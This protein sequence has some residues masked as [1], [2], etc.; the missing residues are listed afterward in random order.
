MP[1]YCA[2]PSTDLSPRPL[3]RLLSG[4]SALRVPTRRFYVWALP[5]VLPRTAIVLSFRGLCASCAGPRHVDLRRQSADDEESAF[6]LGFFCCA[7]LLWINWS[8]LI[9]ACTA[10]KPESSCKLRKIP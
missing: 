2:P 10:P 1:V 8:R 6:Q 5:R 3:A 9:R 7:D 4:A